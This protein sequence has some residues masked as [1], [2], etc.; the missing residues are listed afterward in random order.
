MKPDFEKGNGLLPNKRRAHG[1]VDERRKLSQN[2]RDKGNV[3]LVSFS[4]RAMAQGRYE[5]Q[6]AAC[7]EYGPRLR[8]GYIAHSS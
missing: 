5:W 2:T 3:V 6:C 1:G 4:P 8:W 7:G